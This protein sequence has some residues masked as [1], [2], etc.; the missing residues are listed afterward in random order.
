MN[1][2]LINNFIRFDKRIINLDDKTTIELWFCIRYAVFY[3]YV[4]IRY[5][6]THK[7]TYSKFLSSLIFQ[8]LQTLKI[9]FFLFKRSKV[10]D[11]DVG[12]YKIYNK[13]KNSTVN[14][15]L[16][17]NKID[18]QTISLSHNSKIFDNK[19]NIIFIVNI[20]HFFLKIFTKL[21][22][23]KLSN[24]FLIQKKFN[25]FFQNKKKV[26][27][28]NI[29]QSIYLQQI[30]IL[31]TVKFF[32]R[33]FGSKNVIYLENANLSK[34]IQYCGKKSIKTFDV[35]HSM[36]SNLNILYKFYITKKYDYL[37]TKK[38]ITWGNYW[39][40]FYT[41]NS[42]CIPIG[43][44]ESNKKLNFPKKRKQIMIISSIYSRKYLIKLLEYLSINLES[45]KIIYKLRPEENFSEIKNYINFDAK[46]VTFLKK[47]SEIKL[48]K[49]IAESQYIIGTNST[50]LSESIGISNIIIYKK[51]WY[52]EYNELIKNNIFFSA[53]N[54]NDI[55]KI[56]KKNKLKKKL[57]KEIYFKTPIK[58]T[59]KKLLE[60]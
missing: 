33:L 48:K 49:K 56:I 10:L 11:I 46:N 43:Y 52:K 32:I 8:F 2:R 57:N 51:G 45:Y 36:I 31:I 47:I 16:K 54:C 34:L 37:I 27:F 22:I 13:Q 15:I 3:N 28:L 18:F 5:L 24:L 17:K 58:R 12:R 4:S 59:L 44:L 42:R 9:I 53:A 50:L 23:T 25:F 38:I 40:T 29:Y 20:I 41:N 30:A 19:V 1:L 14:H 21:R 60:K 55:V 39:K 7:K 35:Q 6:K 26:D